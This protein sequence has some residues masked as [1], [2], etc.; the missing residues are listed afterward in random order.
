MFV[1]LL[2]ATY[3]AQQYAQKHCC[4]S[5]AAMVTRIRHNVTL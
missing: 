4:V 1:T 5:M 3:V 2:T